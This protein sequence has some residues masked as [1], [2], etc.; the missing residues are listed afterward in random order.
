MV[1]DAPQQDHTEKGQYGKALV[2]RE[3]R[4]L[5]SEMSSSE[6]IRHDWAHFRRKSSCVW[7]N[8]R[9]LTL[10]GTIAAHPTGADRVAGALSALAAGK[11]TTVPGT[12]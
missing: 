8:Q 2:S 11:N 12:H 5:I 9:N 4:V 10:A 6:S 7:K 3:K 1:T